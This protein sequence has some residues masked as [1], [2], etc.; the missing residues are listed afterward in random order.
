[1]SEGN[2]AFVTGGALD[3]GDGFL[4]GSNDSEGFRSGGGENQG[5]TSNGGFKGDATERRLKRDNVRVCDGEKEGVRGGGRREEDREGEGCA[6][7]EAVEDGSGMTKN[8]T[9]KRWNSEN[10]KGM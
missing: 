10:K 1:M 7:D 6:I 8:G 2:N 3:N 5:L 9:R 4:D